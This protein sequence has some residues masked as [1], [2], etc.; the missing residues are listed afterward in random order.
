MAPSGENHIRQ[1]YPL[2]FCAQS[3]FRGPPPDGSF[4]E[5]CALDL[6]PGPIIHVIAA[7]GRL[8]PH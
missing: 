3:A 2:Y 4:H 8:R 1:R 5:I 6:P 7:T